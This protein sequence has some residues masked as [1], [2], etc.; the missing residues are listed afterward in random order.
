M[1]AWILGFAEKMN[2][3]VGLNPNLKPIID[4]FIEALI[5]LN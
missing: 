5:K 1:N 2:G 3:D 4:K